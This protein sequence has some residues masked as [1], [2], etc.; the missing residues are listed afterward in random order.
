MISTKMAL[1]PYIKTLIS[2]ILK[3]W[4]WKTDKATKTFQRKISIEGVN[5]EVS[6]MWEV[7]QEM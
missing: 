4:Y 3:H 2:K 5:E 1:K 6:W 7:M